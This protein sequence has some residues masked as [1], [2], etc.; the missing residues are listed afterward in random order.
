MWDVFAR[1]HALGKTVYLLG[2]EPGVAEGFARLLNERHPGLVR[3]HHHGFFQ[4]GSDEEREIVA[5][6]NALRPHLLCVGMG[7]PRQEK[8]L[9]R[10]RGTLSCPAALVIG[11]SMAF[12]IGA[13]RRGPAW[14]TGRGLEWVF[15]VL[16][17]PR[18]MFT[19]YFF[20]IPWLM[21]RAVQHAA[22]NR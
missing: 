2:D 20:E 21:T 8:W 4:A 16:H 6:I 12:A 19:R 5:Q 9:H 1:L 14:A 17:E 10:L 18:R 13:R 22:E 15:R 3:G 7:Q 11:A